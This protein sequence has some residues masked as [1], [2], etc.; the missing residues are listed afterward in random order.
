MFLGGLWHGASW[1]FVAW[2]TLHGLAL[3][4]HKVWMRITGQR[5]GRP[6]R[7]RWMQ[8]ACVVV[9]FHFACLCWIFFRHR[10]LAG[11][12]TMLRQIGTNF[13]PELLWQL[14]AGYWQVMV[15]MALGFAL[16]FVPARVE[17]RCKQAFAALPLA[18]Y[19]VALVLMIILI[20]QVKSSDIQPFIY[21]QF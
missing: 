19:A 8:V 14:I 21:F 5:V 3:M 1:N 7:W 16:H 11:A 10:E 6:H 2:G 12:T 9:T 20:I 4:A 15:L 13:H 18:T 17:Q